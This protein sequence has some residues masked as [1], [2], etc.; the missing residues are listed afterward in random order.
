M[1][2]NIDLGKFPPPPPMP[3]DPAEIVRALI[4]A[5]PPPKEPPIL[6]KP[7]NFDDFRYEKC[8]F[9]FM[10]ARRG[11]QTCGRPLCLAGLIRHEPKPDTHQR[12]RDGISFH[13]L[14]FCEAFSVIP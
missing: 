8:L 13:C 10:K 9:C 6:K 14:P 5:G 4:Q 7:A 11:E 3:P 1:S 12:K 2:Q